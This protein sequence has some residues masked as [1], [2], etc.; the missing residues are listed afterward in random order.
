[1]KMNTSYIYLKNIRL[2]AFHGVAP[3]ETIV[4]NE[5][6]INLRIK[7]DIYQASETDDIIKTISYAEA[8]EVV[9]EE[10]SIPSKLLEH[11]C[12]RITK[13]LFQVF[14]SIEEIN[15]SL[16]KRCPPMGGD[17][18]EAGVEMNCVRGER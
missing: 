8:Y 18:E 3:Q 16:S 4:G 11:A 15:I 14:P 17:V 13:R 10:M 2:Y 1:M 6:I 12:N 9:K 7:T 5:F